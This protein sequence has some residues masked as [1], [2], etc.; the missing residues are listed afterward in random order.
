MN[1][2]RPSQLPSCDVVPAPGRRRWRVALPLLAAVTLLPAHATAQDV[3][4]RD[5]SIVENVL[6]ETIQLALQDTIEDINTENLEAQQIARQDNEPVP[7]RYVFRSRGQALA[8]GIYLEDYGAIFTVQVP[9]VSYTLGAIFAVD[10]SDVTLRQGVPASVGEAIAAL[11]QETQMRMQMSRMGSE[12]AVMRRR[13]ERE[14]ESSGENSE[15]ASSLR[16]ALESLESSFETAQRAYTDFLARQERETE[17]QPQRPV[18]SG[19]A[20]ALEGG[21]DARMGTLRIITSSSP[22]ELAAA[23]DL[24]QQQRNQ[25]EGTIIDSVIETLSQYGHIM[26]GLGD[27][28]RLAVVLLPSSYLNPVVSWSRATQRDQEF[29]ISVRYGDVVDLNDGDLSDDD[30]RRQVRI[31]PRPGQPRG[32]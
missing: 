30:F 6:V 25:I 8:R 32:R 24:A 11:G 10:G 21:M 3:R 1:A 29:I 4:T 27:N 9:S 12:I 19:D 2:A 13:L 28:D 22:E 15:S 23:E 18:S 26:H 7:L 20:R 5:L 31:E 16:A 14:V 17:L